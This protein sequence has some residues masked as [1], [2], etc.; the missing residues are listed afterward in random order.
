LAKIAGECVSDSVLGYGVS[1][2]AVD[3]TSKFAKNLIA[4]TFLFGDAKGVE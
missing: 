1:K 4:T 3:S 2:S